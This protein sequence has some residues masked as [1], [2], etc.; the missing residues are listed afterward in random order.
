MSE[1]RFPTAPNTA[2]AIRTAA[3]QNN[4]EAADRLITELFGRVINASGEI[5]AEAL[6][7][8]GSTGDARY[9]TLLAVGLAY[10]LKIHGLP[11]AAW[12]DAVPALSVD[13]VWD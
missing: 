7:R 1:R 6:A 8:P 11:P 13:C 4:I 12:M 9:D 5:P 3:G 10:A 2:A